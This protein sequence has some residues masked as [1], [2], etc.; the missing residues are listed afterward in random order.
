MKQSL[1]TNHYIRVVK[2][3]TGENVLCVFL[4]LLNQEKEFIGY[5]LIYPY[6]LSMKDSD[7]EGRMVINYTKW[8]PF[9]PQEE[10]KISSNHII[11]V[12]FPENE[13][14]ENYVEKLAEFG[15]TSDQLFFEETTPEKSV[16]Q[17]TDE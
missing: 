2:L 10:H 16:E 11:S 7:S 4:D 9:S 15:V 17:N 6:L 14:L 8:C 3:T 1:K 12:V 13:I 5:R